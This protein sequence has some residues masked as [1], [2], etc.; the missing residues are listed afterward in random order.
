MAD[1]PGRA[2]LLDVVAVLAE[3]P[4]AGIVRGQEGTVVDLLDEENVLVEFSDDA[5]R[6]YAIEVCPRSK[7]LVLRYLPQ[8]A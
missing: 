5:G 4:A 7:L 3:L 6:A 1:R 2:D 8:A